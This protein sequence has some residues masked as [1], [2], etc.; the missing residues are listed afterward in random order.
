MKNVDWHDIGRYIAHN[1]QCKNISAHD[2]TKQLVEDRGDDAGNLL[3]VCC[4]LS[5]ISMQLESIQ[6][7]MPAKRRRKCLPPQN[8]R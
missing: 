7:K 8:A 2:K 1:V 3:V 5:R 4:L 6:R